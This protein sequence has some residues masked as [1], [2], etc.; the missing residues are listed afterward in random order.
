M[1]PHHGEIKNL[2][3][4]DCHKLLQRNRF[5]HLACHVKD[6]IYLVPITYT[7]EDGYIYSHSRL[8][9][10]IQMMRKNPHVCVQ[11][12]EV[13]DFFRWK[14]VIVWGRFEELKDDEAKI[15]MRRL[16]QNVAVSADGNRRSELETDFAALLEMAII[17]RIKIER[18]TGRY[19][20]IN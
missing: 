15:A 17:Y 6:D 12:E 16:I 7:F 1:K 20:G 8:G 11:V 19:E 10:K 2:N 4:E 9:Q 5:G 13:D 3:S 18:S 14:S